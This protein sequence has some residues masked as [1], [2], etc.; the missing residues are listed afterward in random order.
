MPRRILITGAGSGIGAGLARLFGAQGHEVVATDLDVAAAAATTRQITAAGGRAQCAQLDITD[1]AAVAAVTGA[2]SPIDVLVNNAGLQHVAR[3][4][5]FP[6]DRWQFLIAVLLT[7]A[8]NMMHAVL[9]TMRA[10]GF[11]RI[12]N[13]GSIHGL[14]AS[15]FK[16]AYVAAK[17]GLLGLSKSVA[18]ENCDV[19]LTVNTIC[20]SYVL[21]PLVQGQI[22]S[23]AR[24]HG[25]TEE[26]VIND[27]MLAPMPKRTF[28][29]I[30]EIHALTDYLISDAARNVTAQAICIDGGWTAR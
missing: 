4:E 19:D 28:I 22:A 17:H 24:A 1:S 13:I 18:L 9:P 16:S 23:Q 14:V 5:D 6:P 7:G 21:T 25:I 3:L 27:I 30:E 12:V 10:R 11:G 15:P 29:S 8:A 2:C 26:R 20:P